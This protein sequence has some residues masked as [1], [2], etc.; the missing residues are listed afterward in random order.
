MRNIFHFQSEIF[1]KLDDTSQIKMLIN[2]KIF[3]RTGG[4]Y[5]GNISSSAKQLANHFESGIDEYIRFK[6]KPPF[7]DYDDKSKNLL[8]LLSKIIQDSKMDSTAL[9]I[10]GGK[11]S[12]LLAKLLSSNGVNVIAYHA[13]RYGKD[14]PET[15]NSLEDLY[16]ICRKVGVSDL[17]VVYG[18]VSPK[19]LLN[20]Y[21]GNFFPSPAAAALANIFLNSS[22]KSHGSISFAQGADTLSNA[23]H[24][25][26]KYYNNS[27]RLSLSEIKRVLRQ[28]YITT[29]PKQYKLIGLRMINS[30]I[31]EIGSQ[32]DLLQNIEL[33]NLSRLAG[34]HLVHTP[35][36]SK[37]VYDIAGIHNLSVFNPF[38][39]LAVEELYFKSLRNP[40]NTCLNLKK[41]ID[42]GLRKFGLDNM[43]FNKSGFKVTRISD[44]GE[45]VSDKVYLNEVYAL[46]LEIH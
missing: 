26:S 30:I 25:Q 9:L 31:T 46:L 43:K 12:A 4:F 13:T 28:M 5:F 38:H 16:T 24:N 22:I 39:T 32:I 18:G 34:M 44:L 29:Y 21:N 42:F 11:D 19:D 10:S 37:F 3:V 41:E 23:V 8:D 6:L 40:K 36:D 17:N 20:A 1:S 27:K 14:H 7:I 2:K 45:V 35:L 33:Q 15:K